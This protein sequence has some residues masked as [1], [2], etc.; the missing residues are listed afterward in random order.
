MQ[1]AIEFRHV[2]KEYGDKVVLKDF[3]LS[4]RKGEFVTMIGSS[5]C[6]KTT[7]LKMVNGLLT[8]D[9]GE[10]FINGENI[11]GKDKTQLRRNIGYAIQGNV[12]FPHMT[13]E[14]NISYVPNL[15]NKRDRQ[16][17]KEAVNKWMKIVGLEEELK[18]RYPAELS[19]GQQQRVGIARALAASPEILL[20]DEPFGAVDEITRSMLQTELQRIY[21]QTDITVSVSYTHLRWVI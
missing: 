20:M 15:L 4:I 19:G 18:E 8:P 17:T 11:H 16:K 2:Q 13:V 7:A 1:T 3:N 12:L 14:Q 5:G 10:L 6:G 9:E 21:R